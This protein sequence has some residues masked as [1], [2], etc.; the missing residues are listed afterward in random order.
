M[1]SFVRAIHKRMDVEL[2]VFA[3]EILCR[4]H[5]NSVQV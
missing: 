4:K 1:R 2:W 3:F 5:E